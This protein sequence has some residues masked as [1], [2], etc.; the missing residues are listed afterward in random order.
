MNDGTIMVVEDD[1]EIA[2]VIA[3]YLEK[4]GYQPIVYGSAEEAVLHTGGSDLIILDIE[5]PGIDGIEACRKMR[6]MT[7]VPIIFLSCRGSESDTILGLDA[8]ADDYITKPFS[9]RSLMARVRANLRRYRVMKSSSDVNKVL[10]YPGLRIDSK[11]QNVS[12]EGEIINLSTTEFKLLMTLADNPDKIFSLD[13][14]FS[15][16][17]NSPSWGDSKTV[18]VHLSNLRKKLVTKSMGQKYIKTIRGKG[19]RF[20]PQLQREK[21]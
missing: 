17:W 3:V 14:L 18:V 20:D 9:P 13:E 11:Q 12:V 10:N 6:K 7:D 15:T 1:Q 21:V 4:D 8:G 2:N 5:L 16:V 19:Y